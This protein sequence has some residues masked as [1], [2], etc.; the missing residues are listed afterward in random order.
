MEAPPRQSQL[1][2]TEV[3]QDVPVPV[4][5]FKGSP[6]QIERQ[7]FE[8][9][10]LKRGAHMRQL[11]WRAI[12]TGTLLGSFLSLANLYVG[13]K[14][15]W[16]LGAPISACIL[17][18]AIWTVFFQLGL[19]KTPL[20][21][22]E[23]NCMQSAATSSA[24]STGATLISAFSAYIMIYGHSLSLPLLFAWVFMLALMGVT[25]AIPMKRQM[26]NIDQLR[27]PTGTAIAETLHALHA[28]GTKGLRAA[29]AL[30]IC[31]IIGAVSAFC[32][33][34]FRLLSEKVTALAWIG[35]LSI[36]TFT[37]YF[38]DKVLG[39]TWATRTVVFNWDIVMIAFGS[40]TG[41]RVC[42]SMLLGGTLCWAVFV[43]IL[44]S[45]GVIT[46]TAYRDIVQWT[47][48]GG[49]SC[50]V[51]SGLF[52]FVLEW[53][54]T[55]RAFHSLGRIFTR[56]R[57][58]E[59]EVDKVETPFSWFLIGQ[60]VGLIG[61]IYLGQITF[62]MPWWQTTLAVLLS[63][64]LALVAC[65]ITGETD[66]TPVGPM[67]KVTQ[68]LFGAISPGKMDINLFSANITA[69]AA[70][71]SADL[72]TDLKSGYL[73]GANPRKQ[74]IAQFSGIFLGTIVTVIG[75]TL[76]VGDGSVLGQNQLPA[77]AAQT[78]RAVAEAMSKGLNDLA[79][80]KVWS[81]IIGG[82]VGI[83]LPLLTKLFPK[84]EKYI[85]SPS[86]LGLAWT[87]QWFTSFQFFIGG[88]IG[89]IFT[90][91]SPK[92]ADEYLFTIASGIIVG[93]SLMGIALIFWEYGPKM[94]SALF[95]H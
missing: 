3:S 34:G 17:S 32:G 36:D 50:M 85:P 55:V 90:K 1:E 27:F 86:G 54:T 65:R 23:N 63:F 13:L 66:T 18:F 42:S 58:K 69:S 9:L 52:S 95:H 7:W 64:F 4:E 29:K 68:M 70:N 48:W 71:S 43:P 16:G 84:Y 10:Y 19:T 41:L 30:G 26:V 49:V 56:G 78:W 53:R 72:L 35:K 61:L 12:I 89:Y 31:G 39:P 14:A 25:M 46:G 45:K 2:E 75:F 51:F 93:G 8:Q 59:D 60:L 79:P 37:G 33:D 82:A 92:K 73:L 81:I 67:G 83:I 15:G 88:L 5:S 80:I 11:T 6:E 40:I 87:F 74:F 20:T 94:W 91:K 38:N 44:Q 57:V 24:S 47:L 28:H 21:I 76:L 77:P 22:L 62:G